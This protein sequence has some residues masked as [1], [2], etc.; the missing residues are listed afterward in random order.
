MIVKVNILFCSNTKRSNFV[1]LGVCVYGINGRF[2]RAFGTHGSGNGQFD[3]PHYVHITRDNRVLVSDSSNH[4]IQF[5]GSFLFFVVELIELFQIR[6][7]N[8]IFYFTLQTR[9]AFLYLLLVGKVL[10]M[11]NSNSH[12]VFARTM[13]ASF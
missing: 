2:L 6:F 13:K 12:V 1:F 9:Q 8:G 3:K 11:V 7:L 4:R 10:I 5:F